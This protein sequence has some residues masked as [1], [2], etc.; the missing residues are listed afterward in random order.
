MGIPATNSDAILRVNP[1]V[2]SEIKKLSPL[3]SAPSWRSPCPSI[4]LVKFTAVL[5]NAVPD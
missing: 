1:N 2:L 3:F 5:K 4:A